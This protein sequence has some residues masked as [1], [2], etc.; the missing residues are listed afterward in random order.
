V[1]VVLVTDR[2]YIY[3]PPN[4]APGNVNFTEWCEANDIRLLHPYKEGEGAFTYDAVNNVFIWNPDEVDEVRGRMLC[5]A[6]HFAKLHISAYY[7]TL[8][9]CIEHLNTLLLCNCFC[10]R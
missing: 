3:V 8:L 1:E 9:N 4:L 5:T 7:Y 6:I 2:G 10:Q